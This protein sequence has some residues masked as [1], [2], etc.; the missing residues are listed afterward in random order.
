MPY[1]K[2]KLKNIGHKI[3]PFFSAFGI[4]NVSYKYLLI[5]TYHSLI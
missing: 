4:G 3:S 5:Q 1:S 2:A